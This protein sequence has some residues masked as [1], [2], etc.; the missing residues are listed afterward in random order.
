MPQ[1]LGRRGY[2]ENRELREIRLREKGVTTLGVQPWRLAIGIRCENNAPPLLVR[3]M[4]TWFEARKATWRSDH[5][6][7]IMRRAETLIFPD[8]GAR[9]IGE[10]EPSELQTM[11]RKIERRPAVVA[12]RSDE[13]CPASAKRT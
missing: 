3:A 2:S 12:A 9:P 6:A 10:T 13:R 11:L 4:R 7:E 1:Q 8:L 5:V